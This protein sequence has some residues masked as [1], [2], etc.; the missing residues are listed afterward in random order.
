MIQSQQKHEQKNSTN[1]IETSPII[2]KK[3]QGKSFFSLNLHS[4]SCLSEQKMT[5]FRLLVSAVETDPPALKGKCHTYEGNHFPH[6]QSLSHIYTLFLPVA[7]VKNVKTFFFLQVGLHSFTSNDSWEVTNMTNKC[8]WHRIA[9]VK[10]N[11]HSRKHVF[12]FYTLITPGKNII[13]R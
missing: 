7:L 10:R 6:Q 4:S 11:W 13:C 2:E 9:E 8:N 5:S 1:K 12:F 3:W